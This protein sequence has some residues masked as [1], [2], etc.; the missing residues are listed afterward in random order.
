MQFIIGF[1]LVS[2]GTIIGFVYHAMLSNRAVENLTKTYINEIIIAIDNGDIQL[3][4]IR[5]FVKQV[6]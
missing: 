2:C 3:E 1:G 4:Q 5:D 6:D